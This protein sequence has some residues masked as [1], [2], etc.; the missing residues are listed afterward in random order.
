MAVD[1]HASRPNL[2]PAPGPLVRVLL[3]SVLVSLIP[4]VITS[5]GSL[6]RRFAWAFAC[7]VLCAGFIV[8]LVAILHHHAAGHCAECD[9]DLTGNTSGVCPECGSPV[10]DPERSVFAS[11]FDPG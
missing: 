8:C 7:V 11:I 1:L 10:N 9:Y 2:I 4:I 3:P 6:E 5:A